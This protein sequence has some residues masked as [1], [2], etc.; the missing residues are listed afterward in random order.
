L[1]FIQK[2]RRLLQCSA[3]TLFC[4][5]SASTL[6]LAQDRTQPATEKWRPKEGIYAHPDKDFISQCGE[7]GYV[8]VSL[9]EK[10]VNGDEWSCRVIKLTDTAPGAIRLDLTCDDYNLAENIKDPNPYE[11]KFKEVMLLRKIDGKSMFL[12]KT[13]NGKFKGPDWR[14]AYCPENAQRS[15]TEARTRDRA[16]AA[17]KAAAE[18]PKQEK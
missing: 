2:R 4:L 10:S 15:Y 17:R 9:G 11:R 6:P 18:S 13:L 12:Q 8:A 14:A 7:S 5:M 16:E 1:N 3:L